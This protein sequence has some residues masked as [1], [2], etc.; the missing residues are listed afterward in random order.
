MIETAMFESR[1]EGAEPFGDEPLLPIYELHACVLE[2]DPIANYSL[3]DL[4]Y[5]DQ[6]GN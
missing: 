1:S 2:G 5:R 4:S 3:P 6:L